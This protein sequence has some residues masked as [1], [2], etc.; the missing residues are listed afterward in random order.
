MHFLGSLTTCQGEIVLHP[1]LPEIDGDTIVLDDAH[2]ETI[3]PMV[4]DVADL[5]RDL[6]PWEGACLRVHRGPLVYF[7][8]AISDEERLR[9]RAV[10]LTR[11]EIRRDR[12]S[13]LAR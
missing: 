1:Y 13:L 9:F 8:L 10:Y 4:L 3:E 2:S 7:A 12:K 6:Q 11:H 5:L